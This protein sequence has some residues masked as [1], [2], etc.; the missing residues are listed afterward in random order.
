[1]KNKI[2]IHPAIL[3]DN[4]K[5]FILQTNNAREYTDHVDVDIIDWERTANKTV[6]VREV[7]S[8]PDSIKM[9]FDLM[10]DYPSEVVKLLIKDRRVDI[11]ILNINQKE[12]FEY[13]INIIK[14]NGKRVGIALNPE[15]SVDE[16]KKY[17]SQIDHIQIYTVEP[18]KQNNPFLK[19]MLMKIDDIT[20]LEFEGTVGV[21]GGISSKTIIN[22]KKYPI[23]FLSVGSELS[24]A[25]NPVKIYHSLNEII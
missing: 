10:M 4:I 3:V 11:I 15:N 13:L 7:L 6:L 19:D 20:K 22:F 25:K 21:D 23:D 8:I 12:N 16:I 17:L 14:E 1:M 24:Q 9:N 2:K 18:G 5:D